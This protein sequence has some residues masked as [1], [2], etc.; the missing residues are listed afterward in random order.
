MEDVFESIKLSPVLASNDFQYPNGNWWYDGGRDD[1]YE[2]HSEEDLNSPISSPTYSHQ[3]QDGEY[4]KLR[5]CETIPVLKEQYKNE[6]PNG[7]QKGVDPSHMWSGD[8]GSMNI[9]SNN[10]CEIGCEVK[11]NWVKES[12]IQN[13]SF[14]VGLQETK[15]LEVK[16]VWLC[17]RK[18][19]CFVNVYAPQEPVRKKTLWNNLQSL[20]SSDSDCHW[21]VF[22][23][24]NVVRLPE[25]RLG[26]NFCPNSA[27]HFNKF[28]HLAGLIEIKM[29]G[30]RFTYANRAGNKHSKLDRYLVSAN[31]LDTWSFLNV[32]AMPRIHSDHCVI[33]L[34]SG[35]LDFG[36]YPFRFFNSLMVD[37]GFENIVKQGWATRYDPRSQLHTS[38][39][40]IT[41]GKLKNLKEHIKR[42]RT[43]LLEM[44][45]K[46][47]FDLSN[48]IN[49]IDLHAERCPIDNEL[50]QQRHNAHQKILTLESSRVADLKQKSRV[51]WALDGDENSGFFHGIINKH[52]RVKRIN[53]LK[54]NGFWITDPSM[55]KQEVVN[56]FRERYSEPIRSRPKFISAKFKKLTPQLASSLEKPFS[57]DEIK[58]AIWACGSDKASGPNG[59]SFAFL[60]KHWDTIG[61]DFYFAV[62]YFEASGNIDKG[63]NS[64]FITLVPKIQDPNT[65]DDF[66]PICLIGCLYKTIAKVLAERLKKVVHLVVSPNQT[67]LIKD[68]YILDGTL[69]LNE[70]ISWL[71]KC[72]KKAFAFKV[73]FEKASDS[74]SW[75]YLDS[76]LEQMNF[77]TKWRS[78]IHGCLSSARISV[79]INGAA[80]SEFSME[81]GIRQ[82]NPLSPFL[83]IIATEGLHIAMEEGKEIGIFEG[84]KLPN[85][86]P[87]LSHL[88]YADDVIFLGSWSIENAKNLICI[89]RCFEL[90]SGLKINMSKSKIYGF[91]VQGCELELVARCLNCSIGSIPLIYLGLPIGASMARAVHWNPH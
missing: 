40:S 28:I 32:T 11:R 36:P 59:F 54:V 52:H 67:T 41:A 45:R 43:E 60:K 29:G 75:G 73:D 51:K 20:V 35:S 24:F 7:R 49:A 33:I 6:N 30:R 81:R 27:Y 90:A 31:V 5:S 12:R 8:S 87:S 2:V 13:R 71:K 74:L 3:S 44:R 79:L 46:E 53:G 68:R 69:I 72:K 82:G 58:S 16:G 38:P 21:F 85:H 88:Q 42:W 83:F 26:P 56:H 91:G 19:C 39:L 57:L 4:E 10:I 15:S 61:N 9:F 64:S 37:A 66:C 63:C 25:E 78:W 17:L 18:R 14:L 48:L 47:V 22:G 65:I 70:T 50:L 89:L 1:D 62:K 77:G 55:I 86:G 80:T 76:I 84:I 34:S 23:D